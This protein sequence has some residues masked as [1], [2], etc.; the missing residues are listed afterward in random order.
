MGQ[1]AGLG[2]RLDPLCPVDENIGAFL[3]SQKEWAGNKG[4]I[5]CGGVHCT[6][7]R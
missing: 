7:E 4:S 1:E 3:K 2:S 5:K 6:A